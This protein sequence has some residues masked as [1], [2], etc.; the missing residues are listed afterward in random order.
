MPDE[1]AAS[2]GA[3]VTASVH[4][5]TDPVEDKD[6]EIEAI[7]QAFESSDLIVTRADATSYARIHYEWIAMERVLSDDDDPAQWAALCTS[8]R[9]LLTNAMTELLNRFE[10]DMASLAYGDGT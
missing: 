4:T 8:E 7:A 10:A 2:E 5:T 9:A 6:V 3:D 1:H